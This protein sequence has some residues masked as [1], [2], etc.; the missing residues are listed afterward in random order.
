LALKT[1]GTRDAREAAPVDAAPAAEA[2]PPAP[3]PEAPAAP[4]PRIHLRTPPA[5]DPSGEST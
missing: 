2:P 3:A 1:A 5:S 4:A